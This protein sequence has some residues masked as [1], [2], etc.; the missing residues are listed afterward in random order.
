MTTTIVFTQDSGDPQKL[1]IVE[2]ISIGWFDDLRL[3][4]E[5]PLSRHAVIITEDASKT[6]IATR[7]GSLA[8]ISDASIGGK[9]LQMPMVERITHTSGKERG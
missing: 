8:R 9:D 3:F 2:G 4:Q 1:L 6:V 7:E 5:T